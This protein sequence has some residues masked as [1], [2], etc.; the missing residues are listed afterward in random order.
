MNSAPRRACNH[1]GQWQLTPRSV[2][3]WFR[4]RKIFHYK[5]EVRLEAA[6]Y[7]ASIYL[8]QQRLSTDINFDK[9]ANLR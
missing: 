4:G 6:Y 1:R 3:L 9:K 7:D 2:S 8:I 5:I